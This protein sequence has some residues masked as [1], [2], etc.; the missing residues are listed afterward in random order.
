MILRDLPDELLE[1]V[2]AVSVDR[3]HQA[4]RGT[5]AEARRWEGL[6]WAV[7]SA[8]LRGA[9]GLPRLPR[10]KRLLG[11]TVAHLQA[12]VETVIYSDDAGQVAQAIEEYP[13]LLSPHVATALED[14]VEKLTLSD[15]KF[16]TAHRVRLRLEGLRQGGR[17]HPDEF[18]PAG[19]AQRRLMALVERFVELRESSDDPR[20]VDAMLEYGDR[21]LGH[22]QWAQVD[23]ESRMHLLS[24]IANGWH[25]RFEDSRAEADGERALELYRDLVTETPLDFPDHPGLLANLGNCLRHLRRAEEAVTVLRV[26]VTA[27]GPG[28][29][30]IHLL[31]SNLGIAA[32]DV[33]I[34][35]DDGAALHRALAALT[36]AVDGH[37]DPEFPTFLTNLSRAMLLRYQREG[38]PEDLTGALGN[39]RSAAEL[40]PRNF[41]VQG[42]LAE[43]L[44]VTGQN[45]DARTS[46]DQALGLVPPRQ[47]ERA[48]YA[49]LRQFLIDEP[50]SPAAPGERPTMDD[51]RSL[52]NTA[53]DTELPSSE[54]RPALDRI[55]QTLEVSVERAASRE[56]EL[57][58]L[59]Q[60]ASALTTR[61]TVSRDLSDL[62]R[63]IDLDTRLAQDDPSPLRTLQLGARL[64]DRHHDIPSLDTMRRAVTV[65]RE[66]YA[67]C[68]ADDPDRWEYA[69]ELGT[70]ITELYLLTGDEDFLAEAL[71]YDAEALRLLPADHP[72]RPGVL[73]DVAIARYELARPGE[74]VSGLLSVGAGDPLAEGRFGLRLRARY[75]RLGDVAALEAAITLHRA[76][77]EHATSELQT[78]YLTAQL[79]GTLRLQA[80]SA[81]RA[82]ALAEAEGLLR[83]RMAAIEDPDAHSM[84]TSNLAGTLFERYEATGDGAALDECIR[85]DEAAIRHT[86]RADPELMSGL[87]TALNARYTL[88]GRRQ[89][90]DRAAALLRQA[91]DLEVRGP[92]R[93]VL[94]NSLGVTLRLQAQADDRPELLAAAAT[95]M[96]QAVEELPPGAP[97]RAQ[98]IANLAGVTLELDQDEET[99][100]AAVSAIRETLDAA[101]SPAGRA[102]LRLSLGRLLRATDE[103]AAAT[104]LAAA[105]AAT[106][107]TVRMKAYRALGELLIDREFWTA[108]ADALVRCVG[109]FGEIFDRQAT[110]PYQEAWLKESSGVPALAA[111]A[112]AKAGDLDRA[113]EILE[114]GRT[115]LLNQALVAR[116]A[117]VRRRPPEHP[118]VHLLAAADDGLAII[119][120]PDGTRQALWIPELGTDLP[121]RFGTY[122]EAL[123]RQEGSEWPRALDQITS[124]LGE[125][126]LAPLL[127]A[128]GTPPDL[129]IIPVGFLAFLPLHAAWTADPAA[130]GGRRYALDSTA[131][132]YVPN[133]ALQAGEAT[134]PS[135][136]LTVADPEP[137][138]ADPL[139]Y[140][141]LESAGVAAH[142]SDA[143]TL[144]GPSATK[145]TV[146]ALLPRYPVIHLACHATTDVR[147]TLDNGPLLAGDD[148]LSLRDILD[149]PLAADLVIASAC[150]TAFPDAGLPD[151]LVSLPTGLLQAGA[152]AVIASSWKVPDASTMVLLLATCQIWLSGAD[153]TRVPEALRSAQRWLR[154]ATTSDILARFTGPPWPSEI[155][156]ALR[157]LLAFE[158]PT[159]TP[160][161][162]PVHWAAFAYYGP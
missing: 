120:R 76:A 153:A 92:E 21:I 53:T 39:A 35:R 131:I 108:A 149:L 116:P 41:Y 62:D 42:H 34:S 3:L 144:I 95:L 7:Q 8:R 102:S 59:D 141:R 18:L 123:V 23:P 83:E 65:L 63:V 14:L 148:V 79:C 1:R 91:V 36:L 10:R 110:R 12:G 4:R 66:A 113:V 122:A 67:A 26:A 57:R 105:T 135:A 13:E 119:T 136:V 146:G 157:R 112:L 28:F 64:F 55:V 71:T 159:A 139:P 151:E 30:R 99:R 115:R 82:A 143:R 127:E 161:A 134:A 50:R 97:Y 160:F 147:F 89:D 60:L 129:T 124:W 46:L 56:D 58:C 90:L 103:Q 114:S 81:D 118:V 20:V 84:L 100:V 86:E 47:P 27:A 44:A 61:Y 154:T 17:F 68:P 101:P 43:V 137:V 72:E 152:K 37:D 138:S 158:E 11:A 75:L 93:A 107:P 80:G 19:E 88:L 140:A 6:A 45:Q 94:R 9:G 128:A 156:Q 87:G 130:P 77:V 38:R 24:D 74:D 126:V 51:I 150:Q 48:I 25:L 22:P 96:R 98:Y 133:A 54:R 16:A 15:R 155:S 132:R 5:G 125:S 32:L 121:A 162:H 33:A 145:D 78:A 106:D 117:M 70:A 31:L 104:E 142:F 69:E 29:R 73:L 85:L 111:H 2:E 109:T 52:V 40:A 49:S